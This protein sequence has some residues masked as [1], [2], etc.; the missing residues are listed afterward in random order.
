M[1]FIKQEQIKMPYQEES[2]NPPN[3]Y[4]YAPGTRYTYRCPSC[5]EETTIEAL[6]VTY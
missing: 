3:N 6:I 5:G 1:P 2:H 4:Y